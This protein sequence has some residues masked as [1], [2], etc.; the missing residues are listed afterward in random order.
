MRKEVIIGDRD[1][2]IPQPNNF[3]ISILYG[4][5]MM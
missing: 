1:E 3:Y 5:Y 2:G 4:Q